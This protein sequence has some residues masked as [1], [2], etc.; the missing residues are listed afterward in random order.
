MFEIDLIDTNDEMEVDN[1]TT[2]DENS[3]DDVD[4]LEDIKLLEK[5][6]EDYDEDSDDG[7]DDMDDMR[8]S[9]EENSDP[10]TR[11]GSTK[12]RGEPTTVDPMDGVANGYNT[13]DIYS[14]F[15]SSNYE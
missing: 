3:G 2:D 9:D 5:I 6:N 11:G 8:D 7:H 12:G 15:Y 13:S 10:P 1:E 4:D 14:C